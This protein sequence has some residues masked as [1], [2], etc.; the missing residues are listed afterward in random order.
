LL[1]G[2]I[3]FGVCAR[4]SRPTC[5]NIDFRAGDANDSGSINDSARNATGPFCNE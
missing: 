4:L 3:L 2:L 1:S 5:Q